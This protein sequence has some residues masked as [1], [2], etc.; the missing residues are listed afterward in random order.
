MKKNEIINL[1]ENNVNAILLKSETLENTIFNLEKEGKWSPNGHIEHLIYSVK[2][3]N[4]L[5]RLPKFF[6][7]YKWG[8]PNRPSRSY[9]EL[10]DKYHDKLSKVKFTTNPFAP[11]NKKI[12]SKKE[13]LSKFKSENEKLIKK[14]QGSWKDENLD[15]YLIPHPLLG[16]LTVREML[17]FTAYHTSHHLKAIE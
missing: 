10:V 15:N 16:K 3:I 14:I 1:I 7:T 9:D 6:M 13:V 17:M 8:K 5:F 11:K 4:Q 2:P 12:F